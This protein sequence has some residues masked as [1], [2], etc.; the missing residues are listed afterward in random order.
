[1]SLSKGLVGYWTM[2]DVDVDSGVVR[3]RSGNDNHANIVNGTYITQSVSGKINEAFE[4][5]NRAYA[6]GNGYLEVPHD[7]SLDITEEIS[8][9]AWCRID[10]D[11]DAPDS[12]V[13]SWRGV[14]KRGSS[15]YRLLLE[16]SGR[17]SGSVYVDGARQKTDAPSTTFNGPGV[18]HF[19]VYTYRSVDGRARMYV[20]GEL[21]IEQTKSIG[22]I[23]TNTSSFQ[24][25][26]TG[27]SGSSWH[28]PI[29]E[30]RLYR[31]ELTPTDVKQL[32]H[33][34][35]MRTSSI[36]PF[37]F[38]PRPGDP[39][40]MMDSTTWVI[41]TS[42]SQDGFN[43]NGSVDENDIVE[44][45]GPYG[46]T[47]ALWYGHSEDDDTG[48]NGPRADGG[49]NWYHSIENHDTTMKYRYSV[50]A[51][52]EF[53]SGTI[54]HGTRCVD[55]FDGVYRTNPYYW[56][57]DLPTMS[58]WY[59]IVGYNYPEQ[60]TQGNESAIYDTDGN[61]VEKI[62]D[63]RWDPDGGSANMR[64][65]TYY[66]YDSNIGRGAHFWDPR[67]EVCDGSETSITEL[68]NPAIMNQ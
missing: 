38:R 54:Y 29:D 51:R 19:V 50:W 30:V 66:Y 60:A 14:C 59:L 63:Y 1:M 47:V 16:T 45:T 61:V 22:P 52:Q 26:N 11:P 68:L 43:R 6:A 41:G 34:R 8:I 49:W 31:R 24:I 67:L 5:E 9:C 62:N 65:R 55:K 48:T 3:D 25:A 42:G 18:W 10:E 39:S 32:S 36:D 57:G 27:G 35:T 40:N 28:G 7:E 20:D 37:K 56:S 21:G 15:P 23:E 46:D 53:R 12:A 44:G 64:W 13:N 4:F 33:F 2:D 17:F 58:D